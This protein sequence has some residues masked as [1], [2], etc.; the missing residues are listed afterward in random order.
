MA[1]L[2]SNMA[3]PPLAQRDLPYVV[4]S[5][6]L[7]IREMWPVKSGRLAQDMCLPMRTIASSIKVFAPSV[8]REVKRF[9]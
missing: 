6:Y 3:G 2:F 5:K 7:S 4:N 8:L 9:Y 1:L